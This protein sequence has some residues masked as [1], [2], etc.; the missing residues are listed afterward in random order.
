MPSTEQ[1]TT[2]PPTNNVKKSDLG[3]VPILERFRSVDDLLAPLIL[4]HYYVGIKHQLPTFH[5]D[6][7]VRGDTSGVLK[8]FEAH[9]NPL[10]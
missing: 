8:N 1:A 10:A 2:C 7:M 9:I 4:P 6:E 5:T 3:T